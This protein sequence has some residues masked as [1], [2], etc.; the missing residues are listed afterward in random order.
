ML[1]DLK[2]DLITDDNLKDISVS[3]VE[4]NFGGM[5][6]GGNYSTSL[7]VVKNL[8]RKTIP[9]I[10]PATNK[11]PNRSRKLTRIFL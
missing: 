4:R 3:S 11:T 1:V 7:E 9:T 5:Q 10:S 2:A 8:L 6:F